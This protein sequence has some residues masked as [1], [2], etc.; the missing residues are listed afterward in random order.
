ML[1][2]LSLTNESLKN[3]ALLELEKILQTNGTSLRNF[4][5]LHMP[6]GSLPDHGKNRFVLEELAYD[7]Y[8]MAVKLENYMS[9]INDEQKQVF[10]TIMAAITSEKGGM[11][12]VYGHGGTW[13]NF[14]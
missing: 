5:S 7:Q 9:T 13:K 2:G 14:L 10:D 8:D 12:F 11:Y 1:A 6:I 3:Y 4:E